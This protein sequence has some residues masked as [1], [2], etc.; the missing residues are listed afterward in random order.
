MSADS[1]QGA[2]YRSADE[3]PPLPGLVIRRDIMDRFKI[4]QS[5]LAR[6]MGVSRPWLNQ[7]LKGRNS[8]SPEF[9]LRIGKVTATD[10]AYWMDLQSRFNLH[11]K[12]IELQETLD[13]LVELDALIDR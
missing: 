11:Q 2:F 3:M 8:I 1:E 10:P 7:M 6:A 5:E 4:S 12:S 13:K 9:A